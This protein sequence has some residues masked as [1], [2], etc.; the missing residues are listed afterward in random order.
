MKERKL[1]PNT[2]N[3]FIDEDGYVYQ[4]GPGRKPKKVENGYLRIWYY[5]KNGYQK[6]SL[7]SHRYQGCSPVEP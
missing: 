2:D 3:A 1:L 6:S 5:D 7:K 4:N